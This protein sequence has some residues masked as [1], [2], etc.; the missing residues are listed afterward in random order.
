[1]VKSL[2]FRGFLGER[3]PLSGGGVQRGLAEEAP[4][5][6]GGKAGGW[7][8]SPA[9]IGALDPY[10]KKTLGGAGPESNRPY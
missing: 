7:K 3:N 5:V 9:T 1:M 10:R 4:L 2:V 8:K 6:L